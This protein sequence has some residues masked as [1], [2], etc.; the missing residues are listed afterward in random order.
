MLLRPGNNRNFSHVTMELQNS[1][2]VGM[3]SLSLRVQQCLDSMEGLCQSCHE[4]WGVTKSG[5]CF[6]G[7]HSELRSNLSATPR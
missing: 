7:Y 5:E 6:R 2:Q 3:D 1:S 4:K